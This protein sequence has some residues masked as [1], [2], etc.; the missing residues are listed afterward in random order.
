MYSPSAY[1]LAKWV[2]SILVYCIQPIIYSLIAFHYVG[3]PPDDNNYAMFVAGLLLMAATGC[4]LG[5]LFSSMFHEPVTAM[6]NSSMFIMFMYFSAPA[7]AV[8]SGSKSPII[9]LLSPISPFTYGCELIMRR[10]LAGQV[11]SD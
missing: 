11:G 8:S 2:I 10:L 7:F 6:V 5:Q 4:T 3:F 1:F 9:D